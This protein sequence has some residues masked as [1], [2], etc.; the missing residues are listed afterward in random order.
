V[1]NKELKNGK[2]RKKKII[3]ISIIISIIFA[4]A[5]LTKA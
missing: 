1:N 4:W 5:G 2:N 3:I